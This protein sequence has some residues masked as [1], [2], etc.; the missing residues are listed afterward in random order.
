MSWSVFA[1]VSARTSFNC[2]IGAAVF[3]AAEKTGNR[4]KAS[5]LYVALSSSP[6]LTRPD[7]MFLDGDI[8]AAGINPDSFWTT[9]RK[10][11]S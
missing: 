4:Q 7:R 10:L 5:D 11:V 2:E 1:H 3:A 8:R 9:Y 6:E